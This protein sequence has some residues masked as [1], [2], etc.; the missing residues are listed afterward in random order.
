MAT[1]SR[2]C[3]RWPVAENPRAAAEAA[4]NAAMPTA[5]NRAARVV[6]TAITRDVID[7]TSLLADVSSDAHGAAIL[8]VGTVR[9]QNDGRAVSGMRYDAYEEMAEAV[10]REIA[11][12]AAQLMGSGAVAV[13]HRIGELVIGEVSVAIAAASPHRAQSFDAARF[14]IEQIKLRLPVWKQEHYVEGD[15]VWLPG[16]VPPGAIS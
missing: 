8:F 7:S 3:P 12:E 15:A 4:A 5:P 11:T 13:V 14:I 1:S 2:C 16:T 6:R 9:E 10:L